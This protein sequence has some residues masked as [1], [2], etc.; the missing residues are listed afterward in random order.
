MVSPQVEPAQEAFLLLDPADNVLVCIR[1]AALGEIVTIDG[2]GV[3]LPQAVPLGHKIARHDLAVGDKVLRY[4]APIGSIKAA[5]PRGGHVHSH[6]LASD[7]IPA[8]GRDAST[9]GSK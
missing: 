7:Y 8:H 3:P 2:M 6:N 5:T 4:G 9:K 1:D